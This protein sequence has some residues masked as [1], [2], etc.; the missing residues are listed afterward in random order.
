MSP[1]PQG[2]LQCVSLTASLCVFLSAAMFR[3]MDVEFP[4][5]EMCPELEA[6]ANVFCFYCGHCI[7]DTRHTV[8]CT[9]ARSYPMFDHA[10]DF[11]EVLRGFTEWV[12]FDGAAPP[13]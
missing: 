8:A 13:D 5:T 2:S 10:P 3:F 7:V 6:N 9:L 12:S 4:E 11:S 1:G